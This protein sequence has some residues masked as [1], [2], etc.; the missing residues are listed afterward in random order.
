MR[1]APFAWSTAIQRTGAGFG[2]VLNAIIRLRQT[3]GA[4]KGTYYYGAFAPGAS[5]LDSA[6]QLMRNLMRRRERRPRP[7]LDTS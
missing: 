3:D 4:P 5:M 2:E 7:L 1:S 6:L